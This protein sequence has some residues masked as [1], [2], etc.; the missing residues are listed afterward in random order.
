M[1]DD[2]TYNRA[3]YAARGQ[4]GA[5][6]ALW[7]YYRIARRY[8]KKGSVLDYGCGGGRFLRYFNKKNYDTAGYDISPDALDMAKENTVSGHLYSSR[9][10]IADKTFDLICSI[11]VLEHIDD[12]LE[13]LQFIR[14][15]LKPQGI[16]MYVVPNISGIGHTL[17]RHNWIGYGDPAHVSLYPAAKWIELTAK[18]GLK[19][20]TT[21]TDGLWDVP[22]IDGIPLLI[23]KII[24]YPAPAFQ[25][26]AGRLVI[27]RQWGESM[28]AIAQSV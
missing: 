21:G 17:K 27:P 16:L 3:Y 26:I 1:A 19:L 10:A 24:F 6:V 13:T 20:L 4:C 18:A 5:R 9:E 11:H 8:V 2:T 14:T 28:I 22:Y 12:P 15:L 25:V 7:F 23:Q